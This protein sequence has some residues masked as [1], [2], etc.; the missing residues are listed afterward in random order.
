M[1]DRTDR[2]ASDHP[3]DQ[4]RGDDDWT[5]RSRETDPP[6]RDRAS[7]RPERRRDRPDRHENRSR[8]ARSQPPPEVR[9]AARDLPRQDPRPPS[10]RRQWS[11]TPSQPTDQHQPHRRPREGWQRARVPDRRQSEAGERRS[12]RP[13]EADQFTASG[14][15]SARASRTAP[16]ARQSPPERGERREFVPEGPTSSPPRPPLEQEHRS[17]SRPEP[18]QRRSQSSRRPRPDSRTNRQSRPRERSPDSPR[19]PT[20]APPQ[21]F[22][23]STRPRADSGRGLRPT[24][25]G[26]TSRTAS[27]P[28]VERSR[29]RPSSSGDRMASPPSTD[30]EP[31]P[32][33]EPPSRGR[34]GRPERGDPRGESR[35]ETPG[36]P[37]G[38]G[39]ERRTT[40]RLATERESATEPAAT[41]V[42]E[43]DTTTDADGGTSSD[44]ELRIG[45]PDSDSSERDPSDP[46]SP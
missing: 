2:A 27:D 1:R 23:Q 32:P 36:R 16:P 3:P 17:R 18:P 34:R 40:T 21:P 35:L 22:G 39:Y 38:A 20:D 33:P 42:A 45:T 4:R 11:P 19:P 46:H 5:R 15:R 31:G 24:R 44:D 43:A 9:N 30:E 25:G 28:D 6:T 12:D 29:G 26:S 8:A 41:R 14:S 10:E 7:N 37:S 13:P